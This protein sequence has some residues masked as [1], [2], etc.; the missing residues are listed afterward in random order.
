ML[1]ISI[2]HSL[3][4]VLVVDLVTAN[5]HVDDD[6]VFR[7]TVTPTMNAMIIT[8]RTALA[9]CVANVAAAPL[10]GLCTGTGSLYLTKSYL[11]IHPRNST[12]DRHNACLG[13][14][15]TAKGYPSLR[16]M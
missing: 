9:Y 14:S 6:H 4:R 5:T 2:D 1:F 12:G 8:I 10:H 15:N 13:L 3:I 11:S 7:T 16:A